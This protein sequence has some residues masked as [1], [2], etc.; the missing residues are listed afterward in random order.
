M[1][2]NA[3]ESLDALVEAVIGA[4]Y[5]VSNVLVS[6]PVAYMGHCVGEYVA[7]A[8]IILGSVDIVLCEVDR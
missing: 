3:R 2:T 6:Y 5:E 1:H 8:V 7:D 4:A